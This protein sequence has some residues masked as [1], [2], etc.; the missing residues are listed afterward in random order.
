[1]TDSIEQI[2]SRMPR[3][4]QLWVDLSR[5]HHAICEG[6]SIM[7]RLAIPPWESTDPMITAAWGELTAP[8]N[9]DDLEK[10]GESNMNGQ[11]REYTN[12]AIEVCRQRHKSELEQAD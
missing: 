2:Y 12:K 6:E 4:Q 9:L 8:E 5:A 1:M 7:E 3:I 10:W 11:T